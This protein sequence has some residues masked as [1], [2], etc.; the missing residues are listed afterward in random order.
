MIA[1]YKRFT[2]Y[3][4]RYI[5]LLEFIGKN[6]KPQPLNVSKYPIKMS[7]NFIFTGIF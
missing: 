1:K 4:C 2:L 5:L 3:F 7:A 6:R